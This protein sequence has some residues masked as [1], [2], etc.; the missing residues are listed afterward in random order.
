MQYDYGIC[1]NMQNLITMQNSGKAFCTTLFR[2][3]L[4]NITKINIE[5]CVQYT[6]RFIQGLT[7]QFIKIKKNCVK[8]LSKL[9]R[10]K[11]THQFRHT[12]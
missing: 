12:F 3:L 7:I 11:M 2:E 5:I 8:I 9:R 4:Q 6:V 10:T 1:D